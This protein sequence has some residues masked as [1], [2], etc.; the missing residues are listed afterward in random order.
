MFTGIVEEVGEVADVRVVPEGR[1]LAIA[2]RTVLEGTRPGDSVMVNGAC[3]TATRLEDGRFTADVSPETCR[4]TTLGA[5]RPG[6]RVNL[7]RAM[8]LG[9]RLGGHLVTGHV[10]G[11]G[12]VRAVRP[13][14]DAT[15]IWFDAPPEVLA[16]CVP[17]GSIAVEGVSLTVNQVDGRGLGVMI[18]PHTA[19]HTTLLSLPPGAG[20]NLESDLIGKYVA[21]LLSERGGGGLSMEALERL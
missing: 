11:V 17:K 7:E 12:R 3:L 18:I 14:G 16:L 4:V 9:D 21:R 8:A 15:E 20:V 2:C 10:D 5:V 6:D 13:Q 19:E 1:V